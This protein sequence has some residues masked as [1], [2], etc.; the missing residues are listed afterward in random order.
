V[1]R[2]YRD[3]AETKADEETPGIAHEDGRR[4]KIIEKEPG[5]AARSRREA[6]ETIDAVHR[7]CY[8]DDPKDRYREA[9]PAEHDRRAERTGD[10]GDPYPEG[11]YDQ[12]R[13]S[14]IQYVWKRAQSNA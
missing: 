11:I 14:I 12:R 3:R 4:R 2:E 7:I 5:K 10:N 8:D 6:V 13:L 9:R 1:R